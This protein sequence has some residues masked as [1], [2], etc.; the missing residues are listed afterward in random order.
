MSVHDEYEKNTHFFERFSQSCRLTYKLRPRCL[1]GS[2]LEVCE[3]LT[4]ISTDLSDVFIHMSEVTSHKA[5][6]IL[7]VE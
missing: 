3:L 7:A 6:V 5:A 1:P 2:L 4:R